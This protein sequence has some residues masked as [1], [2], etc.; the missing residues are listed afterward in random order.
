MEDDF[1]SAL[2]QILLKIDKL[3][4]EARQE[5]LDSIAEVERADRIVTAR[6]K[7]LPFVHHTWPGFIHGAHHE[8]M[9]D[10]FERVANGKLKRLII[11]MPPRHSL[12]LK[13]VVPT[14]N[15]FKTVEDLKVGDFVFG[16]DGQPTKILG[17]SPIYR[18]VQMYRVEASDG[19]SVLCDGDHLWTVRTS[20]SV[21]RAFKTVTTKHLLERKYA[22][23]ACLP[24]FEPVAYP[25]VDLPVDPYVLGAWLGDG[26]SSCGTMAAHPGDASFIRSRFEAAGIKTT[27]LKWGMTF[28]TNG[29]MV[30]LREIGVLNNKHIPSIY[31]T[32]S[33]PQR[34]ALLQGLMD[35]DG[36]VNVSG[37]CEFYNTNKTLIDQFVQLVRS[38]GLKAKARPRQ[39]TYKG[40]PSKPSYV[41][42]FKMEGA[43]SLPRKAARC[44]ASQGNWSRTISVSKADRGDVQCIRVDRED[45]LFLAGNGYLVTHNTK[46][47]FASVMLPA[48]LMGQ[49]PD[50]KVIT[51]THT[52]ELSQRFGRKVRNLILQ[53]EY[54][55]VFPEIV[56]KADSKAA[57]RWD[58]SGGG[59]YYATGVGGALAGRGADLFII[60]DPHDEEAGM[61]GNPEYFAG[62]YDWFTSGPRQRLQPGGAIVIVMTRWNQMDLTGKILKSVR[63]REGDEW[64][65]ITLPAI[66]PNGSPLWPGY[67]SLE[68]LEKVKA[69]IELHKWEAQ[70][71][72]NPISEGAALIK[73]DWW[74]KW[75]KDEAPPCE[76]VIQAWDTA[77]SVSDK[78]NYSAC[79]T[80]GVFYH[81]DDRG[82]DIPNLILLDCL[83]KKLEFPELKRA[84]VD[85]YKLYDPDSIIIEAKSAGAPLAQELRSMGIPL[86]TYT[87]SRG[88]DKITRVN[89][90][91]D[92]FASGIVWA[93]PT[94]WAEEA[95]EQCQAFPRGENDDIVDTVAMALLRFRQGGFISLKT[96]YEEPEHITVTSSLRP[97]A[98]Y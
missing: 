17:K 57:G 80:W 13:E 48:W 77:H 16:P 53:D 78:S 61:S 20:P 56:L 8:I 18:D 98:Y 83:N 24:R 25:E 6:T 21:K 58:V 44:R 74:K 46:S 35:T 28:G 27:D 43:A 49:R 33:I 69:D 38:F 7:F 12:W 67:W 79:T 22:H 19:A 97:Q 72:Q 68:S 39:T 51:A 93:P 3:S 91:A 52:A 2:K 1:K 40:K 81:P 71:Q 5:I 9:A 92:I 73:K 14:T 41:V 45:G 55:D 82:V 64:E 4:P 63:D 32:S 15:G 65:I 26:S 50:L 96:D 88:N 23:G 84:A 60:D 30:K 59:E 29:L 94:R 34:L 86:Q 36:H 70:Y 85:L 66:M 42:C 47:E 10:A 62:V 95:I 31:L 90:I 76:Y 87:P 54:K 89:A 75:D 11:N 37:K